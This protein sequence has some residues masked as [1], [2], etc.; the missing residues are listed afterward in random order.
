MPHHR[1]KYKDYWWDDLP[2][3]ARKAAGVLGWDEKEKWDKSVDVPFRTKKFEELTLI[4]K[5]AAIFLQI[6]LFG[7]YLDIWWSETDAGT[8]GC[9]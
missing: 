1:P 5:Q 8:L 3:E 7:K 2:E 6:D 9:L 4:E